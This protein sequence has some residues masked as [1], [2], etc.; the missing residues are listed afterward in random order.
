M[1]IPFHF[2]SCAYYV[3][4]LPFG[5]EFCS[6][7]LVITAMEHNPHS[8]GREEREREREKNQEE[9]IYTYY[10]GHDKVK[11][12][13]WLFCHTWR[14]LLTQNVSLLLLWNV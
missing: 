10:K 7:E 6:T 11:E 3:S 14:E 13:Q 1:T 5:E 2:P 8:K 4:P 12:R 9:D